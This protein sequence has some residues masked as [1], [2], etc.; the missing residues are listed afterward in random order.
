[1]TETTAAPATAKPSRWAQIKAQA[2][3]VRLFKRTSFLEGYAQHQHFRLKQLED[4]LARLWTCGRCGVF[5]VRFEDN[6]KMLEHPTQDGQRA[7]FCIWCESEAKKQG[8]T[9]PRLTAEEKE[10]MEAAYANAKRLKAEAA[11]KAKE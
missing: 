2:A 9:K 5:A 11:A 4:R 1:M 8:W 10:S 7:L 3:R 6:A